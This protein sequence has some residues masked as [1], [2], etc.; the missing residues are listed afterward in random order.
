[1]RIAVADSRP[2]IP[3][4]PQADSADSRNAVPMSETVHRFSSKQVNRI[5]GD[6]PNGA[7]K[8]LKAEN[9]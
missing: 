4:G 8:S 7:F 3:T 6:L 9:D 1:I 5:L 2:V